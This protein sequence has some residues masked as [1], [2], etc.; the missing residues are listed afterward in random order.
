MGSAHAGRYDLIHNAVPTTTAA[1]V[2]HHHQKFDGTGFPKLV[3]EDVRVPVGGSSIHPFARI[4]A[5]ADLFERLSTAEDGRRRT[6]HEVHALLRDH[7]AGWI[8]PEILQTL[9]QVLPP[10]APGRQVALSDDTR[11]IVVGFQPTHPYLPTVKRI[12]LEAMQIDDEVINLRDCA[13]LSIVELNGRPV[14]PP[15]ATKAA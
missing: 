15:P 6:N 14:T 8:D 13:G 12:R 2:L 1:A 9:P 7:Y 10:F 11:A 5:A 4:L 3:R